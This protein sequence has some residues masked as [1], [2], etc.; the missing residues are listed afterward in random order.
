MTFQHNNLKGSRKLTMRNSTSSVKLLSL[1]VL[2][3][4]NFFLNSIF[5]MGELPISS[6]GSSSLMQ[7][8]MKTFMIK[9]PEVFNCDRKVVN[10][11]LESRRTSKQNNK[12]IKSFLH[13]RGGNQVISKSTY[14]A[15]P[16][17]KSSLVASSINLAKNIIGG[18]MLALPAGLIAGA[19]T[20]LGPAY[21]FLAFAAISSAYT[22]ILV[23]RS[24]EATKANSFKELWERT[25]GEE[26]AWIVD[27]AITMLAFG[28]CV[29][30]GCFVGETFSSLLKS[31]SAIPAIFTSRS[32]AILGVTAF[33]LFPLACL[34]DLSALSY[35]SYVGMLAV[36]YS[37]FFIVVRYFDK[38]YFVGGK[39]FNLLE[40]SKRF[41]PADIPLMRISAGT[42]ILFNMFSTSYMAHT[43]A[44]KFYN[45]LENRSVSRF[46][47]M[48]SA[49]MA[50]ATVLYAIVMTLG[51]F[52]FG[53]NAAG[54]LLVNYF[55][56]D[57]LATYAR[58]ATAISIIGAHPLLFAGLRD[59]F[60]NIVKSKMNTSTKVTKADTAD[61]S[62]I[63][64]MSSTVALLGGATLIALVCKDVGI[65]V[66]LIGSSLGALLVYVF[67][68]LIQLGA[69]KRSKKS[70]D[71]IEKN[72]LSAVS[73]NEISLL[74]MT[75]L[76]GV[77]SGIA[78][79]TITLLS[80]FTNYFD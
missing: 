79:T 11:S 73:K 51:H 56:K 36:L 2:F 14:R 3:L 45:E 35:S 50:A 53:K 1:V 57:T 22:F 16:P 41:D 69:I 28:V 25:L 66:S 42:S 47:L 74:H 67:P 24:V 80:A 68:S 10:L 4:L 60:L 48:V 7:N 21:I 30:Y 39:Y 26:S 55:G 40:P 70:G 49:A 37:V 76:F 5:V 33:V 59:S 9:Q 31:F 8:T 32:A 54:L 18:G 17:G 38:S 27:Y 44:V 62:P 6:E 34:K 72:R 23:G 75:I 65:V 13:S 71:M 77:V 29:V 15:P 12:K 19:G 78:G 43:N 46:T 61:V 20:G 52:T 58:I 64:F 63:L